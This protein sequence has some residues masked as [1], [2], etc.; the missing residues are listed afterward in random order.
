MLGGSALDCES[1]FSL[2]VLRKSETFCLLGNQTGVVL[3]MQR[4]TDPTMSPRGRPVSHHSRERT[5][6]ER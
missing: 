4:P 2:L 5:P 3:S 1:R 6:E